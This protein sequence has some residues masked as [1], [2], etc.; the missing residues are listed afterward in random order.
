M[1]RALHIAS[2][3]RVS[4]SRPAPARVKLALRKAVLRNFPGPARS[5]AARS[6][7]SLFPK[8]KSLESTFA[9]LNQHTRSYATDS[10]GAGD[11][12]KKNAHDSSKSEAREPFPGSV[13]EPEEPKKSLEQ[14]VKEFDE[15]TQSKSPCRSCLLSE[16]APLPSYISEFVHMFCSSL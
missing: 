12:E 7:D 13:L 3:V 2:A 1:Q 8:G 5:E 6:F 9:I 10:K 14:E 11:K 4:T 15:G 16:I